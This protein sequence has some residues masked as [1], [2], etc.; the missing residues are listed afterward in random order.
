MYEYKELNNRESTA[1]LPSV[2]M[3]FNNILLEDEI[4][5]YQTLNVEGRETISY[6][7][8]TS[9]SISGR[10]G[11]V[12]FGKTLPARVLRIQY[13][14]EACDN[15]EFQRSFRKLNWLLET[16]GEVPIR[17][18]DDLDITYY[19]ELSNMSEV[20]ADRNTVIGTF[21]IYCSD[22]YKYEKQ[23]EQ[24]G[25]PL[26]VYLP[27]P[28]AIKPDVIRLTMAQNVTKITVDNVNT[29]RHIILNGDYKTG[30]EIV[31]RLTETNQARKLTKNGQNIMN[32]LDHVETD[33]HEFKIKRNDV[34]RVTP[35]NTTVAIQ[36]RGRWK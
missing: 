24:A 8:E 22:P 30:D 5:G 10:D 34:I 31:I 11:A 1:W 14:L 17:F 26:T 19:G 15:E 33:F 13:R 9:G 25:N 29:G 32:N 28:Y 7:M 18:R 27:T 12:T 6:D 2:A 16:D 36:T 3:L 20:P 35:A 21:E 23:A 4:Q